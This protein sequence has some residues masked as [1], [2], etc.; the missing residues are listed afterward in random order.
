[1][2]EQDKQPEVW[3]FDGFLKH[4]TA[5]NRRDDRSFAFILG[6]GASVKSGIP[7]GATLARQWLAELHQKLCHDGQSVEDWASAETL[8]IAGFDVKNIATFYPQL[9]Y[10]CFA[11]DPDSGYY[12]LEQVMDRA[13]PSLG[14]ALL[15]EILHETRHRVVITTNFDNLI[16]TAL[17]HNGQKHPLIVGHESLTGFVR[18]QNRR[19][20]VA[21]IHRD[22]LLHPIND[23]RGVGQLGEEWTRALHILLQGRTPVVI[24][25]GGNDGSL[26]GFLN[27]LQPGVIA[28]QLFWCVRKDSP[29]SPHV[30]KTLKH[31]NGVVVE[32]GS[33]DE[34]MLSLAGA[35]LPEFKVGTIPER[36]ESLGRKRAAAHQKQLDELSKADD[37]S[38]T[39][40]AAKQSLK[41]AVERD[42]SWRKWMMQ[43][44]ATPDMA[45][46][47]A[48]YRQGLAEAP[49]AE[50]H[51]YYG[52]C[53]RKQGK[54][55]AAEEQYKYALACDPGF[56]SAY[57]NL[58]VLYQDHLNR[59]D[60]AE[61]AYRQAIALDD[62][63]ASLWNGLGNLLQAHL[64]R[65]DEAETAYRQAIA[66]DDK[67][68]LPWNGLGSLLKDHLNRPDEAEAAY[69]Q[70]I[71]RDDK[72]PYPWHG[73]GNLLKDHLNRPD[74]AEAAY[75]QA[76]AL[77][78]KFALPWMG[79]G[80]L[81]L[82]ATSQWDK[83]EDAFDRAIALDTGEAGYL[84]H[85][86]RVCWR[87]GRRDEAE[88]LFRRAVHMPRPSPAPNAFRETQILLAH[89]GLKQ[90]DEAAT[91]LALLRQ[92]PLVSSVMTMRCWQHYD[93]ETGADLATLM[94]Q[95][96]D[97]RRWLPFS[98]AL[99]A[100]RDEDSAIAALTDEPRRRAELVLT[101]IKRKNYS[102]GNYHWPL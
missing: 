47:E 70:A 99:R 53:L 26:M 80:L 6:A 69:R 94:E 34:L 15:A 75:R 41:Q 90:W 96:P 92:R 67:A 55:A 36:L 66:L 51:N 33:F 17:A 62:K 46:R 27:N 22:L 44:E 74:E 60:E 82:D 38:P 54:A 10:R 61:A 101:A 32:I 42:P 79:L 102:A 76:I 87:Q 77:D 12:A 45:Q 1:M 86:A 37:S 91:I 78:D 11:A 28:G 19:P 97:S 23:P 85:K 98:A 65:P 72:S 50:L 16:A 88:D 30:C 43:A 71:A 18:A 2:D 13:E 59:P 40:T 58:G 84:V 100:A 21:K 3:T 73:L 83:A 39:A 9:F 95:S 52:L 64:N 93:L 49:S 81:Y 57:W 8:G 35:L 89:L 7:A 68:A 56:A 20:V 24:G 48:L 29:P 63:A 5:L 25:Y 4:L 31:L 14:Y